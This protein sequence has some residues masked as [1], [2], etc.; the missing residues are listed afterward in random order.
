MCGTVEEEIHVER[1]SLMGNLRWLWS[2]RSII[3]ERVSLKTMDLRPE[4]KQICLKEALP[5]KPTYKCT[6]GMHI[7]A[8]VGV[9][10]CNRVWGYKFPA[11]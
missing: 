7:G 10:I 6:Y 11:L 5:D 8:L 3:V 4:G 2:A 9:P 1:K